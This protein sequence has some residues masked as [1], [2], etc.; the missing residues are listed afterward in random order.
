[1]RATLKEVW[2]PKGTGEKRAIRLRVTYDRQPRIYS[3]GYNRLLT[4][5]EFQSR[6]TKEAKI[7][8]EE[9]E[10]NYKKAGDIAK[11]LGDNFSFAEFAS[12]YRQI[13][14]RRETDSSLFSS[15]VKSAQSKDELEEKTKILYKTAS[16]W[17][18]NVFSDDIKTDDITP[19]HVQKLKKAMKNKGIVLNSQRIY[20]RTLAS[21]YSYGIENGFTK[22]ENPFKKIRGM[23]LTSTRRKNAA[24]HLITLK[25]LL[26]YKPLNASEQMGKDFFI[27]TYAL[28]GMNIGD[29]LR[30]KNSAINNSDE[31]T[32]TR[33]KNS[34]HEEETKISL[35]SVA[36]K[37][38]NKYGRINKSAPDDFILP[39]LA[40]KTN[41]RTITNTIG[42]IDKKVNAGLK[43]IS[44]NM[45]IDKIT[46][47]NARHTF[48]THM[49]ESGMTPGQL[50]PL[51]GHLSTKTTE[52][53]LSTIST[54]AIDKSRDFLEKTIP[55]Y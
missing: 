4:K 46:T 47:Y 53:Y 41:D 45:G 43:A 9:V 3:L 15:L 18:Y 21:I 2:D 55:D 42:R 38:L 19:E 26:Q 8:F 33:K 39:Y 16:N 40:G 11:E 52:N 17:V 36:K 49:R 37:I 54:T 20:M 22:K 13:L 27:L 7:A 1:M 32:F 5:E 24:L 35:T 34:R 48:A 25:K 44:Q 23:T 50:A 10:S 29:I 6:R 14:F 30:L 31:I 28:S 12:R 51:M